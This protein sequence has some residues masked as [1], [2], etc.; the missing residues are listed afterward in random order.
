MLVGLVYCTSAEDSF[1]ELF[2]PTGRQWILLGFERNGAEKNRN[3]SSPEGHS[4]EGAWYEK[5]QFSINISLYL[6][7][8]T[9]QGHSYNGRRIGTRI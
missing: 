1:Q 4:V 9:S 5:S 7:N 8:G 2:G 3:H 6:G